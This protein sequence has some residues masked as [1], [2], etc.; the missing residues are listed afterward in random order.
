MLTGQT[1]ENISW[2]QSKWHVKINVLRI[3]DLYKPVTKFGFKTMIQKNGEMVYLSKID[4][5][6]IKMLNTSNFKVEHMLLATE[7]R[8]DSSMGQR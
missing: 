5:Y 6:Y 7:G 1:Q 3:Y 4:A 2:I 8:L